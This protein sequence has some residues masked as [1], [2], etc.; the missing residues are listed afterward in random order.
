MSSVK[1]L[2]IVTHVTNHRHGGTVQAYGPYVREVD[3]WCD[4]FPEVVIAAP[5][6]DSPPDGDALPFSRPNLSLYAIPDSG[7][8]TLASKLW[9]L[10]RLPWI[11]LRLSAAMWKADAIHV[12]CPGNLGL[13][14]VALGPLFSN[15]LVAKYAGQWSGFPGEP[16]SVRLQRW[17]LG[18]RWWRG[19]VTVYGEWP[20]QPKHVVPF[21]TSV[22]TPQQI[23]R[24]RQ[25][26]SSKRPA[27]PFSIVFVGRLSKAKNVDVLI[28][29]VAGLVHRG[30][31]V[32]CNIVGHGAEY[33]SLQKLASERGVLDRV[34]FAGGVEFDQ[35][36]DFYE[37]AHVLVLASETEGW[38]K[39]IAEAMACGV[40]CV[41]S[42]RGLVPWMLGEGRGF[43]VPPGNVDAL[44][45]TLQTLVDST[46]R[47]DETS[48]RAAEFGQRYSVD[49]LRDAL[50]E[51]LTE[52][53]NVDIVAP[54]KSSVVESERP[55]G[56]RMAVG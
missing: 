31:D 16:W 41:G 4:L 56:K 23:N 38:P 36:F 51:L 7:G 53:W 22:M 3:I 12:R 44:T 46:E 55:P 6:D 33:D 34:H 13:L 40:V 19:I 28:E 2:L 47:R 21:F 25:I 26:A 10:C 43:L 8:N 32:R 42:D 27:S 50:A 9:Q 45:S 11:V 37:Q 49:S 35:V 18:S 52:R 48:R 24:A 54:V 5:V 29:A 17:L 14:G 39:A 20:N 15:K 1:R 30:V